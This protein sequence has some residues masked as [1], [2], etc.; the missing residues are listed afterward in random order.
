MGG[1]KGDMRMTTQDVFEIYFIINTAFTFVMY[2]WF[3]YKLVDY[4]VNVSGLMK[5]VAEMSRP[6]IYVMMLALGIPV[7]IC[8]I[9]RALINHPKS[10]FRYESKE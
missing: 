3:D 1:G 4:C 10:Y 5:E 6:V 7:L 9:F 2:C 8:E